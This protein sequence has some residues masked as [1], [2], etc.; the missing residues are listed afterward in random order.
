MPFVDLTQLNQ[1]QR[2]AIAWGRQQANEQLKPE[3][4]SAI[5]A[6]ARIT[7]ENEKLLPEHQRPLVTVPAYYTDQ[8]WADREIWSWVNAQLYLFQNRVKQNVETKI[9]A[10][11]LEDRLALMAQLGVEPVLKAE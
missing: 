2:W 11:A 3:V 8:S 1:E 6:N 9:S 4:D 5:A 7:A 10:M